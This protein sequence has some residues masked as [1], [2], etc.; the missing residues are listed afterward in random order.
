MQT[1]H[2][3]P[4]TVL[5]DDQAEAVTFTVT[6]SGP[7]STQLGAGTMANVASWAL[8]VAMATGYEVDQTPLQVFLEVD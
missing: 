8:S 6:R 3:G 2:C 4:I 1:K 5:V 7:T